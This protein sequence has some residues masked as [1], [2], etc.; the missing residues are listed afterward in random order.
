MLLIQLKEKRSEVE[1]QYFRAVKK[2][3]NPVA[4]DSVYSVFEEED[5]VWRGIG[6]ISESGLRL[7]NEYLMFDAGENIKVEVEKSQE[8]KGCLCGL[9]IQGKKFP[10]D[11]SLFARQCNPENPIGPCMVSSEGSCQAYFKYRLKVFWGI[12]R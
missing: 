9:V 5:S 3:G 8:P 11:C 2:N 1:N 12:K 10:P 7:K 4:L 6:V